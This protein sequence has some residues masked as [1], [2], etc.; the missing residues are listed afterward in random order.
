MKLNTFVEIKSLAEHPKGGEKMGCFSHRYWIFT[1][2]IRR[3]IT[4]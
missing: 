2:D 4:M 1:V 3:I